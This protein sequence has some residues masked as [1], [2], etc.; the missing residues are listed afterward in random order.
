MGEAE[1]EGRWLRLQEREGFYRM[2][3]K[4]VVL[5]LLLWA[6]HRKQAQAA[7]AQGWARGKEGDLPAGMALS[8]SAT[9]APWGTLLDVARGCLAVG[10]S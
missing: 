10:R 6:E 3:V 7:R 9:R 4:W 1:P 5:C 8:T 2:G